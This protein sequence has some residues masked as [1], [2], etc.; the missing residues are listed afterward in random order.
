MAMSFQAVIDG[1]TSELNDGNP[2]RFK[3]VEG[4]GPVEVVRLGKRSPLQHGVTDLG[5]RLRPRVLQFVF[6]FNATTDAI[7]DA[8][9]QTFMGIFRPTTGFPITLRV[10]RDDGTVRTL[11]CYTAGRVDISPTTSARP[12]H[13]H[14]ASVHLRAHDPAWEAVSA[15]TA[16]FAGTAHDWWTGGGMIGTANVM[17]HTE[18][19]TQGQPWTY[20][21]TITGD[22][23]VAFRSGQETGSG[24]KTAFRVGNALPNQDPKLWWYGGVSWA[25]DQ[26]NM[27]VTTMPA[28]THNYIQV[29]ET[30]SGFHH[31]FL[32][33]DGDT[34]FLNNTA[35]DFDITTA[36]R[37]WRAAPGS[38]AATRWDSEMP[39]VAVYNKALSFAERSALDAHMTGTGIL[40]TV[41]A[42]NGGD[43]NEYPYITIQGPI[44]NP[45]LTNVTT[46]DV[47][48]MQGLTLGSADTYFVD[49][50]DGNKT[51]TSIAGSNVFGGVG[52]PAY[53]A[54][55]YL[56][57]DPIATGGTNSIRVQGGSTSTQTSIIFSYQNHYASF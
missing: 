21:G 57:P 23:T 18:W 2:F 40:G 53:F 51:L 38:A 12:G 29:K 28:G 39:K 45:I 20:T 7:L 44:L 1:T 16:T 30:I 54:G 10:T 32:Y 8:R 9:R 37:A 19:P 46:G 49:L 56:A 25:F 31:L 11:E 5:F 47:L 34:L 55:W 15:T 13:T 48:D 22:W 42:V 41:T 36:N 52:T 4:M 26:T 43:F 33:Y 14:E 6:T 50:R 35:L 24:T 3:S 27:G 17:E